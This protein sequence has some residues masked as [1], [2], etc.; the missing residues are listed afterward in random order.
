[1][2]PLASYAHKNPHTCDTSRCTV[3]SSDRLLQI[4]HSPSHTGYA[5]GVPARLPGR[6]PLLAELFLEQGV[7]PTFGPTMGQSSFQE[8]TSV[9]EDAASGAALH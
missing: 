2:T 7:P 5:S 1:M 8:I 4:V 6:H 3:L 9:A